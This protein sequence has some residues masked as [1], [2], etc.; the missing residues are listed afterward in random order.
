MRTSPLLA[1]ALAGCQLLVSTDEVCHPVNNPE[2]CLAGDWPRVEVRVELRRF[3]DAPG[4]VTLR[5][6]GKILASC[7]ADCAVSVLAGASVTLEA[8]DRTGS[9]FDGW[10]GA[11]TGRESCRLEPADA[12]LVVVARFS[13]SVAMP[14]GTFR[15]GATP[16]EVAAGAAHHDE[17]PQRSV[18]LSAFELD[19]HEVTVEQYAACVEAGACTLPDDVTRVLAC[20]WGGVDRGRHPI[21]C[22]SWPQAA[23]YCAWVGRRLP[24][25]AEWEYAAR[26]ADPG[27]EPRPHPWGASPPTCALAHFRDGGD[28]GCGTRSTAPACSLAEG[29]SPQG[30]CDLAGNVWE[31]VADWYGLYAPGPLADPT[32]PALGDRRV[33]RGGALSTPAEDLRTALR[34][35]ADPDRRFSDFGFRCAA[36]R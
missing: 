19:R 28:T 26:G 17:L 16:S 27:D 34:A 36:R 2:P 1:L 22:L 11:C 15:M 20:N 23:A 9:W 5:S 31:W 35:D 7:D 30:L 8:T 13:P 33:A 10:S 18:T 14:P 32:G 4:L 6:G 25:E 3:S 24:T 29:H 21:N 12:K